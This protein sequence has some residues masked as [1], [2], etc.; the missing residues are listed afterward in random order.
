M[1]IP[2]THQLG[3]LEIARGTPDP[4]VHFH[5]AGFQIYPSVDAFGREIAT[6]NKPINLFVHGFNNTFAES[7]F[8]FAQIVHDV[9]RDGTPVHFSWASRGA[10]NSYVYDR[11][12]ALMARD[13]LAALIVTLSESSSQDV[14]LAAHSLGSLVLMEALVQ[15]THRNERRALQQISQVLLISP[16]IDADLFADQMRQIDF[17]P[18]RV[19]IA[20]NNSAR[21]LAVSGRIT[22]N[23]RRVGRDLTPQ[24]LRTAGFQVLDLSSVEDGDLAGHFLM[25]TSPTLLTFMRSLEG[26]QTIPQR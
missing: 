16:D 6:Q 5:N 20:V 13:D 7:T 2:S 22:G 1:G 19:V 23:Q 24:V 17:P 25:A 3:Q 21:M 12:S 18:S 14:V 26:T 9:D 11:D 15:L 8:R 10:A 4:R